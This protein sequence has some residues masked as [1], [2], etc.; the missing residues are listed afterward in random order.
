MESDPDAA[1]LREVA[2]L[3]QE[4]K[5]DEALALIIEMTS[6][7]GIQGVDLAERYYTLLKMK[8][9]FS[10]ML[11]HAEK[12]LELLVSQDGKAKALMVY[13]ECKKIKPD[14]LPDARALFKLAGWMNETG[15]AKEAIALYHR[16]VK[17]Y[18]EH[19]LI[20]RAFYRVAQIF[21]DRLLLPDNA[22]KILIGVKQKYPDHEI[23]PHVDNYLAH[24][25]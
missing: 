22:R 15:K 24:L 8:K 1:T 21:Q 23:I 10:E 17:G 25:G 2:P 19:Q 4:G 12:Y 14:F 5:L 7:I 11:K 9:K 18:P 20:P 6:V 13:A 16:L 3:I